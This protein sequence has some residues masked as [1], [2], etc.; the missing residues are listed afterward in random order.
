MDLSSEKY[1]IAV[2]FDTR[3]LEPSKIKDGLNKPTFW[4]NHNIPFIFQ[5]ATL[6]V[7]T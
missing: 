2:K 3:R 5:V 1:G 7:A 6:L 4:L